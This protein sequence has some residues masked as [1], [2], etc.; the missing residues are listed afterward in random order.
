MGHNWFGSMDLAWKYA[1]IFGGALVITFFLGF[2]KVFINSRNLAKHMKKQDE[3]A[4]QRANL[5]EDI[6]EKMRIKDEGDLFG[7]RAIEAGFYG[8]VAQS[9]P[10]SRAASPTG[11]RTGSPEPPKFDQ[12]NP[13]R[14]RIHAYTPSPQAPPSVLAG[15]ASALRQMRDFTPRVNSPSASTLSFDTIDSAKSDKTITYVQS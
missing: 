8:G 2:I 4:A 5:P 15:H 10:V 3:E 11:S 13:G 14:A 7:I 1:F 12:N 6:N 9:T